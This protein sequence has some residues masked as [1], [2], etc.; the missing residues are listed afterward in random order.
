M[1]ASA[2]AG[3]VNKAKGRE[4]RVDMREIRRVESLSSPSTEKAA[5]LWAATHVPEIR[6]AS[7]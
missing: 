7:Q 5:V 3:R 1:S 6:A 4:E 2:P